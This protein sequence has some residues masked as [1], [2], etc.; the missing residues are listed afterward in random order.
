ME[1]RRLAAG[2]RRPDPTP[3]EP[4]SQIWMR[5]DARSPWRDE[6][7][8]VADDGV[9]YQRPEVSLLFKTKQHRVK[10]RIDLDGVWPLLDDE[11]RA[12]LRESL[13]RL[14][15]EHPWQARLDA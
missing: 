7:T 6:V 15:P 11:R 4:L 5:E 12:W 9:R 2:D 13:R 3:L 10:D 14:H 8:W 1:Q